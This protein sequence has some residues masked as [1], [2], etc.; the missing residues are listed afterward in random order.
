MQGRKPRIIKQNAPL[1]NDREYVD[2]HEKSLIALL[3]PKHID[4]ARRLV[5][6]AER[7]RDVLVVVAE[8]FRVTRG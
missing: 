4:Y 8:G 1:D 6:E 3:V 7:Q 2:R 5:K